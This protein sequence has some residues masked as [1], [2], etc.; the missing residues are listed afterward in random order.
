LTDY[1][2][3]ALDFTGLVATLFTWIK[4]ANIGPDGGAILSGSKFKLVP[5]DQRVDHRAVREFAVD[6][7]AAAS[8]ATQR[9]FGRSVRRRT[10]AAHSYGRFN[11]DARVG[12]SAA[13]R[14]IGVGRR[15]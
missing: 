13:G 9:G 6:S 15:L 7:R 2:H 14:A 4:K 11:D 10:H 1:H 3:A 5:A 12:K 8:R